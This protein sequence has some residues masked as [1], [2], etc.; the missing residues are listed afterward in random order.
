MC[1]VHDHVPDPPSAKVAPVGCQMATVAL[2]IKTVTI[3]K[4]GLH[5]RSCR[6]IWDGSASG[7][8]FTR[9]VDF[10]PPWQQIG[11]LSTD[12]S[13]CL[14]V[15]VYLSIYMYL[16]TYL[17][18]YLSVCLSIYLSINLSVNLSACLSTYLLPI[19]L[20]VC[21]Y[22]SICPFTRRFVGA[23]PMIPQPAASIHL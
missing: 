3:P 1:G 22:V 7:L 19:C 18:V 11:C 10:L 9:L 5:G 2:K 20:S 14:S 23:P 16:S 13:I 17:S 4:G 8:N 15:C 6:P 21:V 12:L